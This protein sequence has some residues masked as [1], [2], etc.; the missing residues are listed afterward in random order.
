MRDY[1]FSS[2]LSDDVKKLTARDILFFMYLL[3]GSH[4]IAHFP[5]AK[6]DIDTW[7]AN[8]NSV[9]PAAVGTH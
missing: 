4:V 6:P 9:T 3:N 1:G 2:F 8:I 5:G 7:I